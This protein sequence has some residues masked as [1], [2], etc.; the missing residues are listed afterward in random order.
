MKRR[1][2]YKSLGLSQWL[3]SIWQLSKYNQQSGSSSTWNTDKKKAMAKEVWN[4]FLSSFVHRVVVVSVKLQLF[5]INNHL[6]KVVGVNCSLSTSS[7]Q[8]SVMVAKCSIWLLHRNSG[9]NSSP[10]HSMSCIRLKNSAGGTS[11]QRW[12]RQLI[13][14][15]WLVVYSSTTVLLCTT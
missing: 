5:H 4:R 7:R 6:L 2:L 1:G 8:N 12:Y 15:L 11:V 13:K 9:Q 14:C 10:H 3:H